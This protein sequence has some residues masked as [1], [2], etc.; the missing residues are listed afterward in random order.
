MEQNKIQ[1]S[2]RRS[3]LWLSTITENDPFGDHVD[4]PTPA[5]T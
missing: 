2:Y 3:D 5:I 4:R 1:E